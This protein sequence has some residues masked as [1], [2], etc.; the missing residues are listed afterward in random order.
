MN[1]GENILNWFLGIAQPIV[2]VALIV[3]GVVLFFKKEFS[4]LIVL[5]IIAV[6][7]ILLVFNPWGVKDVLLNLGNTIMG[8]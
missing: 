4:K 6:I 2:V 1:I 5:G 7:S 3:S 8:I